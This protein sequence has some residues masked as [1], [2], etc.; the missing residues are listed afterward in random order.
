M[1]VFIATM[2]VMVEA[3]TAEAADAAITQLLDG[4][5]VLDSSIE[6]TVHRPRLD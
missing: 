2:K 3:A 4:E 5:P 1:T 6:V